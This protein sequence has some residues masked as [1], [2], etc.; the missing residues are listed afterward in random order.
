MVA[1]SLCQGR[2]GDVIKQKNQLDPEVKKGKQSKQDW[3]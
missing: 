2:P 1:Q 3:Q